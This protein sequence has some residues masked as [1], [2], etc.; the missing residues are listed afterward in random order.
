MSIQRYAAFWRQIFSVLS[1]RIIPSLPKHIIIWL[2]FWIIKELLILLSHHE[3]EYKLRVS[4]AKLIRKRRTFLTPHTNNCSTYFFAKICQ[5]SCREGQFSHQRIIQTA[6][7]L[8]TQWRSTANN[9]YLTS[10]SF[11]N[12]ILFTDFFEE[13]FRHE[14]SQM[15]KLTWNW[16]MTFWQI[17]NVNV[18]SKFHLF[19]FLKRQIITSSAQSK[20]SLGRS[21]E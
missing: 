14:Y 12:R 8:Q 3:S 11:I 10:L 19:F 20:S 16:V 21:F 5:V 1:P 4:N 7:I 18:T 9:C 6:W 2:L 17:W 15:S 13:K